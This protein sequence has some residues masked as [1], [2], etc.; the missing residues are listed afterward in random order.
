MVS[1]F[2]AGAILCEVLGGL[3]VLVGYRARIGAAALIVFL[4]P[5]SLIFHDFWT[6]EGMEQQV[7]MVMFMKNLSIMGGLLLVM[8]LGTGPFSLDDRS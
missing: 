7:Q 1:L 4:I 3:S 6:L 2:L 5:A 8:S